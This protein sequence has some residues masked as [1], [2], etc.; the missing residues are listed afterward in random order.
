M[1]G[2][3]ESGFKILFASL[4]MRDHSGYLGIDGRIILICILS[5]VGGH[6]LMLIVK[7]ILLSFE[8]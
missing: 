8:R 7:S 5:M 1:H 3:M 4:K 6:L 2:K